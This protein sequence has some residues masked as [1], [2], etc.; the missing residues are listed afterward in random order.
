MAESILFFGG[1]PL[2]LSIINR[3]MLMGYETVV[4]DPDKNAPAKQIA[5]VF[6]PVAG[7]DF[8]GTRSIALKYNVKGIVTAATDKP[9]LMMSRLAEELKLPFPSQKSCETVLDKANFKLFLKHY[10]FL[11]AKGEEYK[12]RIDIKQLDLVFPVI[13]KPVMNSGSRGVIKCENKTELQIAIGETLKYCIN[14]RYLIEEYIEGDEMSLEV[15]VQNKKVHLLQITD[16]IVTPP[17]YNVELGHIQPSKYSY[18]KNEI[19]NL[20]QTI[21]D[22]VGLDNCALHPEI[23]INGDKIT[24]IEIGPRLGGDFITSHLVPLSTEVNIED[25]LIKISV[26]KLIDYELQNKASLV[27]YLNFPVGKIIK[28]MISEEELKNNIPEVE[29]FSC[30]LKVGEKAELISNSLNRYGQFILKGTETN[31]L[32]IKKNETNRFIERKIF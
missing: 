15:L 3:A 19:T 21:V 1:G 2:Q 8:E 12:G 23:K 7:N 29:L 18:L 16:K 24:I 13:I 14:E 22:K 28:A 25:L 30:D 20:I 31:E 4:I 32:I 10:N 26:G 6:L 5:D 27:S 9:I 11:H 17:P